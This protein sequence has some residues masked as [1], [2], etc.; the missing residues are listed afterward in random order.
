[1][2]LAPKLRSP[3]SVSL[4]QPQRQCLFLWLLSKD[5]IFLSYEWDHVWVESRYFV[6]Q[7]T[8]IYWLFLMQGMLFPAPGPSSVSQEGRKS[9]ITLICC[10]CCSVAKLY[11]T[12]CNSMNCC[13]PG[14]VVLRYLPE[15]AQTHVHWVSDAIQLSHPLSSPSPLALNLSQYQGLFQSGGQSI[16]ASVSIL[17]IY[18]QSWFPLGLTGFIFLLTK[19]LSRVFSG[20]TT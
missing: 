9:I 18:I 15:F 19:G 16:G 1:M 7:D 11:L 8:P 4:C 2:T 20:I 12:L 14:F 5:G 17:P 3:A 13:T 10:C 6:S